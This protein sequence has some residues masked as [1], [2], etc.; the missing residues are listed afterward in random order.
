LTNQRMTTDSQ[1]IAS[2]GIAGGF[3]G[4]YGVWQSAR[5]Q[6]RFAFIE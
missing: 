3:A 6:S 5:F 2:V 1:E 4:I